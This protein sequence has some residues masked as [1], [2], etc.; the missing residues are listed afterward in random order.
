MTTEAPLGWIKEIQNTLID[1]RAIPLSGHAPPS[2]G[3]PWPQSLAPSYRPPKSTLLPVRRSFSRDSAITSGLGSGFLTVAIDLTPLPGQVYWLMGKEDVAK[4][5]ALA[6]LPSNGAGFSSAKFQEGFYY[7]LATEALML[8][9]ELK[10][11]GG[12]APKIA[13]SAS[14]PEEESL[15]LDIEIQHPKRTFWGRLVC[16]ASFH[17]AFKAHFTARPFP[18]FLGEPLAKPSLSN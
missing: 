6:L 2:P 12:L 16:P 8:A 7:Y 4:L 17:A 9:D 11:F 10:A 13:K 15:C 14:L 1:A 3:R 5:T 18:L